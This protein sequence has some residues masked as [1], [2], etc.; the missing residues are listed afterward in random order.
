MA[1]KSQICS[2]LKN[3]GD[4]VKVPRGLWDQFEKGVW[5]WGGY[6]YVHDKSLATVLGL[7]DG[8]LI[9]KIEEFKVV[10]KDE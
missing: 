8:R 4:Q 5:I 7:I 6:V 1:T 9:A 10:E 3:L 2:Y